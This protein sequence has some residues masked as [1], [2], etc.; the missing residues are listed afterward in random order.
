MAKY[1]KQFENKYSLMALGLL[2]EIYLLTEMEQ[3][4]HTGNYLLTSIVN[5]PGIFFHLYKSIC[6]IFIVLVNILLHF[7]D[8]RHDLLS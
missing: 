4:D 8:F 5:P 7:T 1:R 3:K 6:Q 2:S